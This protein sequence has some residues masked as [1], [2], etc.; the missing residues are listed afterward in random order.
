MSLAQFY[1]EQQVLEDEEGETIPLRLSSE[2]LHHFKVL[3]MRKGEHLAV[4]DAAGVYYE[5]ELTDATWDAPCV[6]I[7]LRD[8]SSEKGPNVVLFQGVA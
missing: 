5:C 7:C 1:L 2:D 4:I 6:R 8:D 3:R